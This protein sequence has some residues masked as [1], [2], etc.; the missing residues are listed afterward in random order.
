MS[1]PALSPEL[2]SHIFDY[3]AVP[4]EENKQLR[5]LTLAILLRVNSHFFSI[6]A[7]VLYRDCTI[8]DLGAFLL[9]SNGSRQSPKSTALNNLTDLE[10]IREGKSKL[11][12]LRH[13][14][15]FTIIP[16]SL[17]LKGFSVAIDE[18]QSSYHQVKNTLVQLADVETS[19]TPRLEGMSIGPHV[20]SDSPET[21]RIHS[22]FFSEIHHIRR[23][24]MET[25]KP[26]YWCERSPLHGY[27]FEPIQSD[28]IN[29]ELNALP[30]TVNIH[31]R[32]D[33][34]FPLVWGTKNMIS[35]RGERDIALFKS[36]NY[37][38]APMVQTEITD[39]NAVIDPVIA[40]GTT[41]E[42]LDMLP[43]PVFTE[44][45]LTRNMVYTVI[46]SMPSWIRRL[47]CATQDAINAR[48]EI[49]IYGLEKVMAGP[50][51]DQ[52]DNSSLSPPSPSLFAQTLAPD[53][54]SFT[55]DD[56]HKIIAQS[57]RLKKMQHIIKQELNVSEGGYWRRTGSK[58]P[59][60]NLFLAVDYPGCQCCGKGKHGSWI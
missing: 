7:S 24:L 11:A 43:K 49:E 59:S 29:H 38:S 31:T 6:A 15:R 50:S 45:D 28:F 20:F 18:Q 23:K 2:W 54:V 60:L 58:A 57:M 46:R 16:Y 42:E 1:P 12:L 17:G 22:R 5:Q 53:Q 52:I 44:E 19:I 36:P 8:Q 51:L 34:T 39:G 4:N 9:G 13:V 3:C 30:E 10:L 21:D 40:A 33:G 37:L 55:H 47:H 48:T 26:K 32:L 27:C 25:C 41:P 14:R 56:Q 35:I